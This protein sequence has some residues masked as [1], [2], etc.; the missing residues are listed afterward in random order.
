MFTRY[1]IRGKQWY[2]TYSNINH[3]WITNIYH[4]SYWQILIQTIKNPN[5][6]FFTRFTTS[7]NWKRSI[8]F[9]SNWKTFHST[10]NQR[11]MWKKHFVFVMNLL[12]LKSHQIRSYKRYKKC[13]FI[14]D[15]CSLKKN[16][17]WKIICDFYFSFWFEYYFSIIFKKRLTINI[18]FS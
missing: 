9:F 7:N 1:W 4:Y 14:I 3:L 17:W 6:N 5:H 13:F 2:F 12:Q 15:P 8:F 10:T 11:D 18:E 16:K